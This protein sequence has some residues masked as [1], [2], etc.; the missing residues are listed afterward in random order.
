M[1]SQQ[2]RKQG[3]GDR[4][5]KIN[6]LAM[7]GATE[8]ERSAATAAGARI[9]ARELRE[10]AEI[11]GA[12]SPE[13]P[14]KAKRGVRLS[15]DVVRK[16]VAPA[17]GAVTFW[18]DDLKAAGFGIRIYASGSR[19]FFIN[20][21][22]DGREKRHTIGSFPLWTVEAAREKAKEL[23]RDV[24]SGVDP[25]AKK[26]ERRDAPTVGDLIDRYTADHLPQKKCSEQNKKAEKKDA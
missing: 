14:K 25:A 19:S 12:D 5:H 20:Y 22:I 8:G 11:I 16:Q 4:L 18:D 15:A 2:K 7:R 24:D 6:A 9:Q 23:R 17:K 13:K 26:Q 10:I 1:K 21:R 3:S